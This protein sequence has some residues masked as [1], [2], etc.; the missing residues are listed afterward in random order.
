MKILA[1][2]SSCDETAAAIVEDGRTVHANVISSQIVQHKKTGGVVPEVAAREHVR[3]IMPVLRKAFK[4]S[5]MTWDDI[6]AIAVTREPGLVGC[7]MTGR[8]TAR[9]LAFAQDKPLLEVNHIHGHLYSSWLEADETPEFPILVLTVSGGHND[10]VLMN[11]HGD[12]EFLGKTLDDAGGEAF[13]KVARMLGLGY[14]GG[15]VIEKR[16]K[17][18]NPKSVRFPRAK[19]KGYD[20]SFSGLKTAVLYYLQKN[21]EQMKDES[22][23]ND[24]AASFQAALVDAEVKCLMRAVDEFDPKEVHLVGGCSANGYMREEIK[25]QLPGNVHFRNPA[26]IS[27]CTD[28]AAMIGAVAFWEKR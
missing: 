9:S 27:Y 2:E 11:G 15:P 17:E 1:I 8:M 4:D 23:V 12:Y 7:V 20:F 19:L 6:D 26:K 5:Q 21:E 3:N 13:D 24:I 10:L 16:A 25:R 14:P 28:N 18:G 22:F